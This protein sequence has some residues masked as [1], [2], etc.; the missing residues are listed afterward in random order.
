VKSSN[1]AEKQSHGRREKERKAK[2]KT[3]R[4]S[5]KKNL[6]SDTKSNIEMEKEKIFVRENIFFSCM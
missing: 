6:C 3:K 1:A 5:P 2:Q 4:Q